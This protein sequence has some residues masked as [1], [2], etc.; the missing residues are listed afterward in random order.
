MR[1]E[2][3]DPFANDPTDPAAGLFGGVPGRPLA[4][5]E[6]DEVTAELAELDEF[7]RFLEP[8][9]IRGVVFDCDDCHAAHYVAWELLRS[10]LHHVLEHG[11]PRLHEPAYQ[12]DPDHYVSWE[13]ARGYVDG[14]QA[15]DHG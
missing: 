12:P 8:T 7:Q 1:D 5:D 13:Y 2:P 14:A 9:G 15:T 10:S 6:R 3:L 4:D 11:H